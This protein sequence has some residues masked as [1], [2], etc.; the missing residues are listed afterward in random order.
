MM[1]HNLSLTPIQY[2]EDF[3]LE[4][5]VFLH[6]WETT[7]ACFPQPSSHLPSLRIVPVEKDGTIQQCLYWL[8]FT[9]QSGLYYSQI[10]KVGQI[11]LS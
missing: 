3:P 4:S 1:S 10:T 2:F 5:T 8:I 11:R 6:L 9:Q 7:F